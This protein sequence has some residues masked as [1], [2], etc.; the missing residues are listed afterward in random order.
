MLIPC[1]EVR[2]IYYCFVHTFIHHKL[3]ILA[4]FQTI[5][6]KNSE[7]VDNFAPIGLPCRVWRHPECGPASQTAANI[8][9]AF[10]QSIVPVLLTTVEGI[11]ASTG[12]AGLTFYRH[13]VSVGL[14]CHCTARPVAQQTQGV[15]PVCV[16]CWASVADGGPE[17]NQHCDNVSC[18]LGV[19]TGHICVLHITG[20]EY[21]KTVAQMI[22]PKDDLVT[23]DH[24]L[25]S[26][27]WHSEA[28]GVANLAGKDAVDIKNG[29]H[30]FKIHSL[31]P[32]TIQR[33]HLV[34]LNKKAIDITSNSYQPLWYAAAG[35]TCPVFVYKKN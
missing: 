19:L 9:P 14:H 8:N 24:L 11:L 6:W 1:V 16:L 2:K 10:V 21:I 23:V 22:E 27:F 26:K 35:E 29:F 30:H 7:K 18:F 3:N 13:W 15:E 12:D 33:S 31:Y 5:F 28:S 32:S 20:C 4:F 34:I 17:L 25:G